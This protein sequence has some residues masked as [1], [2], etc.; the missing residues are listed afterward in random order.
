MRNSRNDKMPPKATKRKLS[1]PPVGEQAPEYNYADAKE[2][3]ILNLA[4][5]HQWGELKERLDQNL[6]T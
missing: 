1:T 3:T 5:N 4:G 2:I 6:I